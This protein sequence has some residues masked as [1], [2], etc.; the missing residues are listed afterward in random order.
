MMGVCSFV[1]DK[2]MGVCSF[3]CSHFLFLCSLLL[4]KKDALNIL[5]YGRTART[6]RP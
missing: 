4:S 2:M 5:S 6:D 3:V 1:W